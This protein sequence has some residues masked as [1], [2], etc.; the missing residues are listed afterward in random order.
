MRN[1]Q[2]IV[3][4]NGDYVN[5]ELANLDDVVRAIEDSYYT[6]NL[7]DFIVLDQHLWDE[8]MEKHNLIAE[9]AKLKNNT[10]VYSF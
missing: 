9:L 2:R 5:L 4:V 7:T 3:A 8:F 6:Q 10:T 1:G